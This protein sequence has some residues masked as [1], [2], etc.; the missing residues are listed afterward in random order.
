MTQ[1]HP[2]VE[3]YIDRFAA[4]LAKFECAEAAEIVRDLRG[5]IAEAVELGKPLD[6]VL[7]AIG[8]AETLARAYAVELELNPRGAAHGGLTRALKVTGIVAAAS[9]VSFVVVTALGSLGLSFVLSGVLLIVFGAFEVAGVHFPFVQ[10]AGLSPWL[11]V[12]LGPVMLAV[13][14]LALTGLWAYVRVLTRTLR[15]ALPKR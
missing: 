2:V 15:A 4:S 13:G 10:T 3:R 1:P 8:P 7:A 5:H 6:D 14:A 12:A 11:F 9:L